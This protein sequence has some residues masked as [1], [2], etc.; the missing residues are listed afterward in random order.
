[1]LEIIEKFGHLNKEKDYYIV[2]PRNLG[3]RE[4]GACHCEQASFKLGF[5]PN[6]INII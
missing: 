1:V 2:D 5:C 6:I 4:I 3:N